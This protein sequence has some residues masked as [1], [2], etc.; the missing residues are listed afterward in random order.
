M[1]KRKQIIPKE[2]DEAATDGVN[3][4]ILRAKHDWDERAKRDPLHWTVNIYPE[5]EWPF[6]E[7]MQ[8]G[9]D[10]VQQSLE[11]FMQN[12]SIAIPTPSAV[13]EIGSGAGR[14]TWALARRFS[15][16]IA[17]ELSPE[18]IK[19]AKKNM[20]A[21]D[22]T[23]VK[24]REL[25]GYNL[26]VVK[27]GEADLVFS[28]IVFQHIPDPAVQM[29]YMREINRILKPGGYFIVSL[30]DDERSY[31]EI[32]AGWNIRR[33]ANDVLGWSD[34][35]KVEL[36]RY[37]T[38]ISTPMGYKNLSAVMEETG[39]QLLITRGRGTHTLWVVGRKP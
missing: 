28:V 8:T 10:T 31:K 6:D 12:L 26:D 29:E 39:M 34:L 30:Y 9:E 32:V 16:V 20:A 22:I 13:V 14:C 17:C 3:P 35:A 4:V 11:N 23:N 36:D 18:M 1:A 7:Y 37:E 21:K 38:S 33:A 19:A 27:D 24:F 5:G 15:R 2:Y 25:N